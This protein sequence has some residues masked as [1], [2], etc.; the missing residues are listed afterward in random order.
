MGNPLVVNLRRTIAIYRRHVVFLATVALAPALP[1]S[2]AAAS[3][4]LP[5]CAL[6][7]R[8]ADRATLE[9]LLD[10]QVARYGQR[11][12]AGRA[13]TRAYAAGLAA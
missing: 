11:T 3:G 1:G 7:G 8:M 10:R 12:G 5:G 9:R 4:G 13:A 6:A 2:A